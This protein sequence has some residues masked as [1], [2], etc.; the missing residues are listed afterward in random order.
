MQMTGTEETSA[1]TVAV[2][3]SLSV[4]HDATTFITA[5]WHWLSR[6]GYR[7]EFAMETVSASLTLDT[8]ALER[9]LSGLHRASLT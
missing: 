3:I 9:T 4:Y 2:Q 5:N 7:D 1:D 6:M 8:G